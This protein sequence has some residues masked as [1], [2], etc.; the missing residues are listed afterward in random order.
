[1]EWALLADGVAPADL[2]KLLGT[3]EG[4]ARAFKKLDQIKPNVKVWFNNWS[5]S[6][7]LLADGEVA[8]CSGTNGRLA[9]TQQSHPNVKFM[10]D[11]MGVGGDSWSIPKGAK[12]KELAIKFVQFASLP[13]NQAEF[14]KYIAYGP[15]NKDAIKVMDPKLA[16]EMPSNPKNMKTSFKIDSRWWSDHNDDLSI[17]FNA[18]LAK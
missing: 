18:W 12:N 6:G 4:I 3:E 10:W 7:Q 5:Q 15:T 2:Y 11:G 1:M 8:M 13:E 16:E 9:V 14:S 17:R